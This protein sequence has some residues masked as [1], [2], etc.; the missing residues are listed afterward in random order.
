MDLS[1]WFKLRRI[2]I[3]FEKIDDKNLVWEDDV[4]LSNLRLVFLSSD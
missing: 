4:D 1:I 2:I 3:T